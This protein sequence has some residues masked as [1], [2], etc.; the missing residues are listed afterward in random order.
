MNTSSAEVWLVS[1]S[2]ETDRESA[3]RTIGDGFPGCPVH[4]FK[5]LNNSPERWKDYMIGDFKR[6]APISAKVVVVVMERPPESVTKIPELH[7]K[8]TDT[9]ET[10]HNPRATI[11]DILRK[12]RGR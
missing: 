6:M 10:V 9:G 5:F 4:V 8:N 3:I 12:T 11:G 2:D 1:G 7:W